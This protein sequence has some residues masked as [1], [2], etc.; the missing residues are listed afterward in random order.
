MGTRAEDRAL[1]EDAVAAIAL[2]A[3]RRGDPAWPGILR[4][5]TLRPGQLDELV[6]HTARG[7]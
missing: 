2:I 7:R 6:R 3:R 4:H 5:P 1:F